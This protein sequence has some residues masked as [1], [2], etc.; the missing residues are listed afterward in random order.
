[1]TTP[2]LAVAGALAVVVAGSPFGPSA[3]APPGA[4]F[5]PSLPEHPPVAPSASP[6][7]AIAAPR[8]EDIV[9]A[10]SR[11]VRLAPIARSYYSPLGDLG[12]ATLGEVESA[13]GEIAEL[14]A[15]DASLDALRRGYVSI[16]RRVV[17]F[18]FAI[19]WSVDSP[20]TPASATTV[21]F[22]ETH[23]SDYCRGVARYDGELV[24]L[25][26]RTLASGVVHDLSVFSARERDRITFYQ[27]IIRPIGSREF[28]TGA[29][30][31]GE[32]VLGFIQLGRGRGA[33]RAFDDRAIGAL[34]RVLPALSLGE[35]VRRS[36]SARESRLPQGFSF[37]RREDQ[38][39]QHA[40]LGHT[41]ADIALALGTS[42]HTVR[43][44]LAK[45]YRKL[46]VSSRAELVGLVV[47]G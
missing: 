2:A 28:L 21:G 35:A 47:A 24:P 14:A 37:T 5:V 19:A 38:I 1:V 26:S 29:L 8:F 40:R 22:R 39:I 6:I 17:D 15:T 31:V 3:P 42:P 41:V 30:R 10:A 25:I 16:L 34:N 11:H 7:A 36:P 23:F 20:V 33:S 12:G 27:D 45:L 43:N 46:G 13:V 4:P 44:Q 18:D 32:R 9:D